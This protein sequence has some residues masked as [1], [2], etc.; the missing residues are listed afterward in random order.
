ML[1]NLYNALYRDGRYTKSFE[2]FQAQFEDSLYRER[3]YKEVASTGE[4]TNI[5][6]DFESKYYPKLDFEPK[7][8]KKPEDDINVDPNLL[9]NYL[10]QL[11]DISLSD[12]DIDNIDFESTIP[13][14]SPSIGLYQEDAPQVQADF[15]NAPP[16]AFDRWEGDTFI[17][18]DGS[19]SSI[20][21]TTWPYQK[22]LNAKQ[23]NH[24][25][26]R[27]KYIRS[28]RDK[29]IGEK[30]E[31]ILNELE[32]DISPIWEDLKGALAKV[33]SGRLG[34]EILTPAQF[35]YKKAKNILTAEFNK[36]YKEKE[37]VIV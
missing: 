12:D 19:F 3:V 20:A 17:K 2:E 1:E 33:A 16:E 7:E 24:E 8:V 25:E 28:E 34:V 30:A 10:R 13:D 22:F 36:R 15:N 26:A 29:L 23:D 14:T 4:Y 37:G 31:K 6:S 27:Q 21:K 9:Q 11:E 32:D 35:E 5:F 18:G